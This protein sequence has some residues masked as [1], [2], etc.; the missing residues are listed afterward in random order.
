MADLQLRKTE[1]A[2]LEQLFQFQIDEEAVFMA[3]FMSKGYDDKNA[4]IEKYK[5]F[6]SDPTINMRTIWLNE[7][8]V[9]SVAK[10]EMDGHAEI[11]YWIDKKY[12]GQ[13]IAT[14]A[15]NEFLNLEITRPIFGHAAFDNAG[16]QRVL[17]KCGFVMTGTD[18]GFALARNQVIEEFVYKL[19]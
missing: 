5:K 13:G 1:I 19:M 4:Y 14:R 16:S 6:L 18:R 12:W 15:L 10:Y 11:T 3:G 2:D 8:I 9:G 17:E 7:S